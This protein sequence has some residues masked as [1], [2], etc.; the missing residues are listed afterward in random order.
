MPSV[1]NAIRSGY[2]TTTNAFNISGLQNTKL[3]FAYIHSATATSDYIRAEYS[4][5]GTNY[6][7]LQTYNTVQSTWTTASLDIPD[8]TVKV[9]FY[10][11]MVKGSGKYLG[12]DVI[13]VSGYEQL[14]DPWFSWVSATSGTVAGGSSATITCGYDATTLAEGEYHGEVTITSDDPVNPTTVAP[15]VLTVGSTGPVIPAAPSIIGT[16]IVSGNLRITWDI[17]PVDADVTKYYIYSSSLPY[18][19]FT[20]IGETSNNTTGYYDYTSVATNS[21]MFFYVTGWNATKGEAPATI[22]IRKPI[23][24]PASAK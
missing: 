9:R 11:Y 24:K 18:G 6:T 12:V 8:N 10:G 19:T 5:D 15:V 13:Q 22:E 16:S 14:I 20:K 23:A 1:N 21:K 2:L 3:S 4:T 7:A 17:D